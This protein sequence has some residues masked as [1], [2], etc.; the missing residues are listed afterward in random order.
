MAL[1]TTTVYNTGCIAG[2]VQGCGF[3]HEA[4][5]CWCAW[6][7]NGPSVCGSVSVLNCHG[8][9]SRQLSNVAA[10]NTLCMLTAPP[11]SVSGMMSVQMS[12]VVA[13]CRTGYTRVIV[14]KPFGK[15]SESFRKLSADLYQHL[16]EDQMYRIDHYLGK[17]LI[18]NL[19]VCFS[20]SNPAACQETLVD[21]AWV[22]LC[23][24]LAAGILT[25]LLQRA[26]RFVHSATSVDL[27]TTD[28][29]SCH[30]VHLWSISCAQLQAAS[31]A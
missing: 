11:T 23:Y 5:G 8:S 30:L 10:L 31:K 6:T 22:R 13:Q 24:W 26:T 2:Q 12:D 17:E 21:E 14:E 18:E 1:L 29:S 15:D 27:A 4:F 3:V 28:Y 7:G 16:T 20:L 25:T 9:V 19:T